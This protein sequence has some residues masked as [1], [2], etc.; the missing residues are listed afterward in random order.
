M[1]PRHFTPA[2]V[3]DHPCPTCDAPIEFWKDDV[4]RSCPVCG[5]TLFNP[6]IGST[7]LAWCAKAEEC[8]GNMDITEWKR[9]KGL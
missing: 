2:D 5:Q 9:L 1:N 6:S 4:K 3:R 8:L 7:C